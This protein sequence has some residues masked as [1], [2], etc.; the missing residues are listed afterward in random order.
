MRQSLGRVKRKTMI[1][2]SIIKYF[3]VLFI[4]YASIAFSQ[5][6]SERKYDPNKTIRTALI[7]VVNEKY[8]KE[9]KVSFHIMDSL[10]VRYSERITDPYGTL[11]GIIL[12]SAWSY[13]DERDS[14]I[15]GIFKE[16]QI[17]WD[18]YPGTKAGF[19]GALLLSRDINN[20]GAVEILSSVI[21]KELM[22]REGSGIT[23]LWI[24]N[25]D[26]TKGKMLN[27]T[28]PKTAQS[29]IVSTDD[30]Y[31]LVGPNKNG[32]FDIQGQIDDVWQE[33]FTNYRPKTLPFIYYHWNGKKYY[34]SQ[35]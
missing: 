4:L 17:I 18:D 28:D 5:I 29:A 2:L 33:Y 19:G 9:Y 16:N 27:D 8:G 30:V 12:F 35:K 31:E 13:T 34:Y 1:N 10:I 15:T 24:L 3:S 22:T 21:D 14:V 23:Y 7:K 26:G 20:D 11:K 6:P 25:W 32:V